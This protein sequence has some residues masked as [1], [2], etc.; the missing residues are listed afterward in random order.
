MQIDINVI[1][2]DANINSI[3]NKLYFEELKKINKLKVTAFDNVEKAISEIKF[4]QF[5]ET[6]V[7]VS[8]RLFNDFVNQ[9][10]ENLSEINVI[11]KIIIFTRHKDLFIRKYKNILDNNPFCNYGGVKTLFSE[12]QNFIINDIKL[13]IFDDKDI[14]LTFERID[15]KEKLYLPILYKT[16]IESESAHKIEQYTN[17]LYDKYNEN[18]NLKEL[19]G[20]I[21]SI[22]KIP[23]ELLSKY[24]ARAYTAESK[25]YKEMN[26][27]LGLNRTENYL[28][29]IKVLYEGIKYKSFPLIKEEKLYRGS[30]ISK[31]EINKINEFLKQKKDDL[32]AGM[33]Y[34][35]SF[36]SFTKDESIA[37]KFLKINKN[38]DNNLFKVLYELNNDKNIEYDLSTYIDIENISFLKDEKEVLFLPFSCFVIEGIKEVKKED[39]NEDSRN[40]FKKYN[41]EEN[42]YKIDLSYL[43]KYFPEIEKKEN[44]QNLS[45]NLPDS[46][47]KKNIEE[48]GL[49]KKEE[50]NNIKSN[51]LMEKYED[52]KQEI[53]DIEKNKIENIIKT[54]NFIYAEID[55]DK[56]YLNKP[57]Q[58]I[59]S[60][61][62]YIKNIDKNNIND[63]IDDDQND[64][65]NE[66]EIKNN[67]EIKINDK[68][69][70]FSYKYIFEKRG[71]YK[72]EYIFKD[73][74][75]KTDYMFSLCSQI[76]TIDLTNF[77]T[78]NVTNMSYM[79][80]SCVSLENLDLTNID[81]QNVTNMRGMFSYCQFLK[82]LNI[83]SFKTQNVSNMNN[84]YSYCQ[85]LEKLNLSNFDTH[86]V[87]D[88]SE[89]FRNCKRLIDLD[90]TKFN[91]KNV[92][93]M[94]LMFHNCYSLKNINLSN[95][96]T[97]NL[98]T[99]SHMF[100]SC[101]NLEYLNLDKFNIK[102]V[103]ET[104]DI[105]N[106]CL[107]LKKENII[108]NDNILKN[109]INKYI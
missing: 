89:M 13:K 41:L 96:E 10:Y 103:I 61:E 6:K 105:F 45:D 1:W 40:L 26:K 36:L 60:F 77:N 54:K 56:R 97:P 98:T 53:K 58:I 84:M 32:P 76:R 101:K 49:I 7:I 59:N 95:F 74:L 14:Q 34:S 100:N 64:F 19:F 51:K 91:T 39:K 83:S 68:K 5:K 30:L 81:T 102:K 63:L 108:V 29:Y 4:I 27:D 75:T 106:N 69:I 109:L 79:F 12:I 2:I 17:K 86:N 62:N 88:L 70:D 87:T 11:P 80:Y 82:E 71:N 22:I 42:I 94:S 15:S 50:I 9:L 44:I 93:D 16:L 31:D 55:I 35:K 23:N 66:E 46:E 48:S 37:V 21:K 8:G 92:I 3:E 65:K 52:L 78:K 90:L 38:I 33:V 85:N 24:Y 67:I 57:I 43:G 28:T 99:I 20:S 47:F 18:E 72:I 73:Y 107:L 104:S 25:F